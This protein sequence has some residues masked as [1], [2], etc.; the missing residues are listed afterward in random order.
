MHIVKGI[1]FYGRGSARTLGTHR[2]YGLEIIYLEKGALNWHVQGRV[3]RVTA[4]SVF[5][6]L[7][8]EEHGSVDEF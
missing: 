1:R 6:S 4:G 3:E 2:D 5:F 7:P 8:W